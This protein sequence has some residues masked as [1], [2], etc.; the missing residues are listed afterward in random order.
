M[1]KP[2]ADGMRPLLA[3]FQDYAEAHITLD[4][5][6]DGLPKEMRG[7]RPKGLPHSIWEL[8]EHIRIA[9]RDIL[10]FCVADTYHH[11]KWPDEYW[12]RSP[13]PSD[14]A[15]W[16]AALAALRADREA[17]R[18]LAADDSI[19]LNAV[20]KHGD[21]P[22]QTYLRALLLTQDHAAYHIGQIVAVKQ[23]LTAAQ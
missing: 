6:L 20:V 11:P 22:T 2:S 13:A 19:D 15:A 3:R 17:L 4:A 8:V 18:R 10:D 16:H 23:L 7:I 5:A 21:K 9:Q 14:D 12:P 1:A